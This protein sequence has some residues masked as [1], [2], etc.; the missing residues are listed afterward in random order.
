MFI[1]KS[2]INKKIQFESLLFIQ[3]IL[4]AFVLWFF[5]ELKIADFS[6]GG[7]GPSYLNFSFSSIND[8]LSSHRTFGLPIILNFYKTIFPSLNFWPIFQYIIYSSAV[9]FLFKSLV[10]AK[11]QRL[12][13]F[14][15][16]SALIWNPT[17]AGG[18]KHPETEVFT[19]I[20]LILIFSI[21]LRFIE[22]KKDSTLAILS[23]LIFYI[24]QIR[25]NMAFIIFLV[26][27]WGFFISKLITLNK[28]RDA[29]LLSMKLFFVSIFPLLLFCTIRLITVGDFGM[30]SFTGTVLSGHATSYLSEDHLIK[31]DDK[32]TRELAKEILWRKNRISSPCNK[33]NDLSFEEQQYC[34]NTHI[35]ISWLSAIKLKKGK[36]PFDDP[37]K[38]IEPWK[39][40]N[41]SEFFSGDNVEIDDMLKSYSMRIL[42]LEKNLYVKST[43]QKYLQAFKSYFRMLFDHFIYLIGTISIILSFLFQKFY[44][45]LNQIKISREIILNQNR[46]FFV[47][48]IISISLMI[49]GVL[50]TGLIIHFDPRYL[51]SFSLFF[52]STILHLAVPASFLKSKFF[53]A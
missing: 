40:K 25:P 21:L 9:F 50:S 53:M 27:I 24:Y 7:D 36:E 19:A 39:Y 13:S 16:A 11:F 47:L 26:P 17:V 2:F 31:F 1:L 14:V 6:L 4:F 3:F 45:S 10:F 5:G 23:F 15:I 46:E 34:G 51:E 30:A 12:S 41:L 37:E 22:S 29:L 35:M 20:F 8:I 32:S 48:G 42:S 38:N 33:I 44:L 28:F 49:S 18:F 52:L 43:K